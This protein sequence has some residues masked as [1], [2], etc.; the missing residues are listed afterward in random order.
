MIF[1]SDRE[2]E[3]GLFWQRADGVGTAERL[4]QPRKDVAHAPLSWRV[5]SSLT[6]HSPEDLQHSLVGDRVFH[7]D[8]NRALAKPSTHR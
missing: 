2:G 1:Q 7:G 4:T 8:T 3:L 5:S 6:G